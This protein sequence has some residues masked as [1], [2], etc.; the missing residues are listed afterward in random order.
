M[1]VRTTT[2]KFETLIYQARKNQVELLKYRSEE[3]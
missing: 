2:L 3:T 1:K